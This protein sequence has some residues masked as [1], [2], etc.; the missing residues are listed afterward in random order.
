LKEVK[1]MGY[2]NQLVCIFEKEQNKDTFNDFI[3]CFGFKKFEIPENLKHGDEIIPEDLQLGTITFRFGITTFIFKKKVFI[4]D[5]IDEI[6]LTPQF[7]EILKEV[8]KL[9]N[10]KM[11][12]AGGDITEEISEMAFEYYN[13]PYYFCFELKARWLFLDELKD[14]INKIKKILPKKELIEIIKNNAKKVFLTDK[15]IGILKTYSGP[16]E[17]E[18]IR[19][20]L[21]KKGIPF[22][23]NEDEKNIKGAETG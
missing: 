9:K 5:M 6:I 3:N 23:D 14:E 15:G 1:R 8:I 19:K 18:L 20:E 22:E 21:K 17:R 12:Y 16:N 7:E 13:D 10:L 4:A 2:K 11:A